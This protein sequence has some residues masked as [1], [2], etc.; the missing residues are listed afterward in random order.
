MA[1][2][3]TSARAVSIEGDKEGQ[4]STTLR[5]GGCDAVTLVVAR[6][7]RLARGKMWQKL[8]CAV[9]PVAEVNSTTV[10]AMLTDLLTNPK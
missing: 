5:A 4:P 8:A 7:D 9:S 10:Q 3:H 2:L 6:L 1:P